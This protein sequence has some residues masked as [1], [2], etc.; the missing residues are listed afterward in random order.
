[1][2]KNDPESITADDLH[3]MLLVARWVWCPC[4]HS[5]L[6]NELQIESALGLQLNRVV[7]VCFWLTLARQNLRCLVPLSE[8]KYSHA[9]WLLGYWKPAGFGL[10]WF[11]RSCRSCSWLLFVLPQ[12]P[13]AQCGA[14]DAVQGE[15]DESKATRGTAQ[16]QAAAAEMCQWQWT[17]TAAGCHSEN[18]SNPGWSPY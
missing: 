7:P 5:R 8:A 13:V 9:V 18:C 10:C 11:L 4:H 1:M 17:L 12:V 3:K 2:R 16:G 15:V 14:D 6:P